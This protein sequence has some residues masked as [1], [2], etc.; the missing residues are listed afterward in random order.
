MHK[1]FR[2]IRFLRSPCLPR[3]IIKVSHYFQPVDILVLIA[4]SNASALSAENDHITNFAGPLI[5]TFLLEKSQFF[6][7]EF[8]CDLIKNSCSP[9]AR[10]ATDKLDISLN[11]KG[12]L[13]NCHSALV[14]PYQRLSEIGAANALAHN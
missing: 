13:F 7:T 14:R 1:I 8:N 5:Y 10:A 3:D 2:V 9:V 12:K 4:G 11:F 6:K